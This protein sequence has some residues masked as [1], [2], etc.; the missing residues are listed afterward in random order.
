MT[1][2]LVGP[3]TEIAGY[4][5]LRSLGRGGMGIVYLAEQTALARQVALKIIAPELAGDLGFRERF[6]RESRIAAS[7]DHPN[8]I[9]VYEAGEHDGVLFIAMRYVPGTDLR[10]L[11][12]VEGPLAPA[13]AARLIAQIGSAL[14]AAHRQG[15]V[16]RDVK[17]G[18]ILVAGGPDGEHSYLSDFGLTKHVTSHGGLTATGQWVGTLDYVA[19]EQ[20]QGSP[21]DARADVYSLGCVLFETLTGRVPFEREADMAKLFAHVSHPPPRPSD[22]ASGL[23]AALDEV[24]LRALAKQPPD[25]YQSAGDLGRAAMA[26]AQGEN[27]PLIE[28]SVATGEAAPRGAPVA[29]P[30]PERRRSGTWTEP[31]PAWTPVPSVSALEPRRPRA[32][33]IALILAALILAGGGIAAAVITTRPAGKAAGTTRTAPA[34]AR[35][36]SQASARSAPSFQHYVAPTYEADLPAGWQ[37]VQ[38]Y[39]TEGGGAY[40]RTKLQKGN[41]SV[42]VD[43]TPNS[44][45]DPR[46]TALHQESS[47]PSY[48]RLRWNYID[49]GSDTA[50]DWA[51]SL[52]GERREDILFFR[53][54]DGFG[55]LGAA[56]PSRYRQMLSVTRR[57]AE[58]VTTR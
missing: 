6:E 46:D 53:G 39:E 31:E 24:V 38:D 16:H 47:D 56:P 1:A 5:V 43:T 21:V 23:P 10:H 48:Q 26:V 11:L 54:G 27:V 50:F 20:V 3:G 22:M 57:V 14:D 37:R 33:P 49:L 29:G 35:T 42:L 30:G 45:G 55:V 28:G 8:V 12:R 41:M 44:S 25:R 40:Y 52:N 58:S 17:P 18:N 36:T 32:V 7:L 4:T 19:P 51:F 15:L 34:A 2:G 13:R 9:P